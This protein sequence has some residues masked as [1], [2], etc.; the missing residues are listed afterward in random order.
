MINRLTEKEIC[1][2]WLENK[3]INPETLKQIKE[4]GPTYKKIQK[5]CSLNQK[6]DKKNICYEWLKNKTINPETSRKIKKY[7]PVYKKLQNKCLSSSSNDKS[8]ISLITSSPIRKVKSPSSLKSR[9]PSVSSVSS[10]IIHR[11]LPS[12]SSISSS[13]R[14]QKLPSVSSETATP[15]LSVE[16]KRRAIKKIHK[17]FI[18]YIKRTSVN[19]IDRINY[20]LIIRKYILS[21]KDKNNCLK[22]Y[23]F[24]KE[25]N[26]PIYRVG[27]NIILD[28]QIGSKSTYGIVFLSHFK[29]NIKY[30][31]RF[32]RINKFA[33]KI[34]TQ[35]DENKMEILILKELTKRV[36]ELKCPH[37]PI[38]Y[39]SLE[40]NSAQKPK[41]S[42]DFSIVKDKQKDKKLFPEIV[43]KNRKLYIQINELA[44]GDLRHKLFSRENKDIPNSF[45]QILLSIMF[46][47]KYINAHHSDCH[48]G[49]FLYH[50]IK[51]GGYFHYNIYGKDYYLENQGFLWV[52]WDFGSIT[53]FQNSKQVN[54]NKFGEVYTKLKIA[55]DYL[56]IIE[57]LEKYEHYFSHT[58]MKLCSSIKSDVFAQYNQKYNFEYN[59]LKLQELQIKILEFLLQ[60]VSSFTYMKPSNII[61]KTPYIIR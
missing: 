43:N 25:T 41:I 7:G 6:K 23:N 3:T 55:Y 21:I 40:C 22:L 15:L 34:T 14:H 4:N 13:I 28:K 51:P 58:F 27:R 20:F 8:S 29:T 12:V 56:L 59:V 37:F 32:D 54:N 17:L 33:V 49:N 53:P 18:P 50:K 48:E 42:D 1:Y 60:N 26:A 16:K 45:V 2:K 47:H 19:L 11:R 38:T 46:F 9:L 52:I 57:R 39:G 31:T 30:G 35:T 61:N 10:S 44:A 36:I 24:D 5:K